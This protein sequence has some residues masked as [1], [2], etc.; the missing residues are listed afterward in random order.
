MTSGPAPRASQPPAGQDVPAWLPVGAALVVATL[1][2]VLRHY[3]FELVDEGTLLAQFDRVRTG[4]WPYRD[5]HTGYAPGFFW[6]NGGLLSLFGPHLDVVRL[7]LVATHA[8][9]MAALAVLAARAVGTRAAA[10]VVAL[11]VSFFLP[12]APGA[13]CVWS[14]PYPGWYAQ[15]LGALALLAALAVPVHGRVALIAAG[16][17]WGLAFCVKQNTGVL[18]LAATLA[19]RAFERAEPRASGSVPRGAALALLLAAGALAVASAGTLGGFGTIAVVF[20]VLA[21]AAGVA[22]AR[23]D[24]AV[25]GDAVALGAGFSVVVVPVLLVTAAATGWASVA[26][27]VLHL[28]SGAAAVYA[29]R[30]P[31]GT[32]ILRALAGMTGWRG[33]RQAMDLVWFA[34]FPLAHVVAA[35]RLR[36]GAGSAAWRLAVC[37]AIL[38]YV[39]LFPRADFW[40]LLPL[41]GLSLTVAVGVGVE[42]V[43][44]GRGDRRIGTRLLLGGL[45]GLAVVRWLPNVAVVRAAMTPPPANAPR[46]A[47][48]SVRWDLLSRP[49]LRTIPDVV[50]ALDD[51]P[52]VVGFPA[53]GVFNFLTGKPSPL[54]H[55]YFFP[56]VPDEQEVPALLDR[57][58]AQRTAR[59]VVLRDD[60]AF[61]AEAL[62]A[63]ADVDVAI[64]A[65][66]PTVERIGPYEIRSAGP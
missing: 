61:F 16:V 65:A 63:H 6:L 39:Q 64:A 42:A 58:L 1:G 9:A 32:D 62:R 48:A 36:P 49:A 24:A 26:N 15:A 56:G 55:D 44:G 19:W 21:L 59:V 43:S 3:G 54:R 52:V 46:L 11:T 51:A 25:V 53:L 45:L 38:S 18:G 41:A 5:F 47:R 66:F 13:F 40:H 23:P 33:A 14:I 29:E 35:A 20:P 8:V 22:R 37:A 12:V 50:R 60:V 34:V 4:Q 10:V 7:G 27:D 17:A 31:S 57:L 28:G 2:F 30:Y